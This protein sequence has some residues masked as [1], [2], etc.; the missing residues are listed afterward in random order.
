MSRRRIRVLPAAASDIESVL[1]ETLRR[2]GTRKYAEYRDLIHAAMKDVAA[3]PDAPPAQHRPEI[4]PLARTFHIGR[5]GRR[6]RHFF[7]Y[8]I[9]DDGVIEFARLLYD[10]MDLARHLPPGYESPPRG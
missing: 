10:G 6:A 4:H 5:R 1:V 7:L 8:R 3:R 9:T 2:F